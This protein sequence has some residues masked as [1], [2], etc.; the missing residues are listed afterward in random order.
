MREIN[1]L[2]AWLAIVIGLLTGTV[3]G[4]FFHDERWMGGYT[5]W[6]RRMVRLGHVSFF[7]TAFLNLAF[8]LSV[9]YLNFEQPPPIASA[10]FA[11]G[12]LSMPIVCFLSAW[13]DSF[14][15]FFF[16][17]VGSLLVA[18]ADFLLRGIIR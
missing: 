17:P 18:S 1:F 6:R 4:L 3:F 8:A 5:S 15:H 7:G 12:A 2:I 9:R 13:R 10:G 14:R 16:I 11:M